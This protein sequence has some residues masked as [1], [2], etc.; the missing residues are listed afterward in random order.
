MTQDVFLAIWTEREKYKPQG[1][2]RGYLVSVTLH[3]CQNL[4][5]KIKT[6]TTY[7]QNE[8]Q[9]KPDEGTES[10]LQLQR[11]IEQEK[12]QKVQQALARIPQKHRQVLILRFTHELSLNEISKTTGFP[13]GTVKGYISRGLNRLQQLLSKESI[14]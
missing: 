10:D 5:R 11:I 12:S 1:K 8:R 6:Q 4:T 9:E 3:R 13:L 7:V 14:R 2:F